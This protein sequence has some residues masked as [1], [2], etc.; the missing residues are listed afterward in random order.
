MVWRIWV[1]K[2]LELVGLVLLGM[3]LLVGLNDHDM[4]SEL[5][6]LALGSAVFVVGWLLERG[7]GGD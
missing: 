2:T 4:Q 3:A 5:S 7:F 6:G 1:A